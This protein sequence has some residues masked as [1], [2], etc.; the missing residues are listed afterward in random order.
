LD[1][2]KVIK[3]KKILSLITDYQIA[4]SLS[5]LPITKDNNS[6]IY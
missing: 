4:T 6:D 5:R 3:L 2:E 1:K